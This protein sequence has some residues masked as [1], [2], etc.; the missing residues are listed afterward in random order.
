MVPLHYIGQIESYREDITEIVSAISRHNGQPIPDTFQSELE[1]MKIDNLSSDESKIK[2]KAIQQA[3]SEGM[4]AGV[5]SVYG[6]D[7][8]CFGY[9]R[10]VDDYLLLDNLASP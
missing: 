5:R 1:A 4:R 2:R 6:Q 7:A 10:S 3:A 8:V 9:A